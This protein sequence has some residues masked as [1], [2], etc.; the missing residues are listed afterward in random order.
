MAERWP[1]GL[2]PAGDPS[3]RIDNQ[4]GRV[5]TPPQPVNATVAMPGAPSAQDALRPL[6]MR[7]LRVPGVSIHDRE[8]DLVLVFERGLFGAGQARIH[9]NSRAVLR[10]LAKALGEPDR[11]I[12]I[13]VSGLTDPAPPRTADYRDNESLALARAAAVLDFLLAAGVPA[14]RLTLR[15][16]G[17]GP[18]PFANDTAEGRA[19]NRSVM[20]RISILRG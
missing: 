10:P 18:A 8:G 6:L 7:D 14:S 19:R 1:A 13:V 15:A 9:A 2:L 11:R 5:Q 4:M 3:A 12:Q 16:A 17:D 20:I